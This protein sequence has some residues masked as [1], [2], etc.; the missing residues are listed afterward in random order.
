MIFGVLGRKLS[1]SLSPEIHRVFGDYEYNVFEKEP[2]EAAE[3]IK[4]G[5]YSGLNITVPYKRIA[6]E[7]ADRLSE[8]AKKTKS[9]NTLVR[10]KDGT[11]SGYNT[12]CFGFSYLLKKN[13]FSA[14]NKKVLVLGSGGAASACEFVLTEKGANVTVISRKGENNYQNLQK[15]FDADFIVNATPIGMYPN[16]PENIISL[17]GFNS[18]SGVI[19]LIYNPL[20]TG[21]L[22]QA[23][24]KNIEFANGT[25]MLAAQGLRSAELF[26]K[27]EL[28]RNLISV[29]AEKIKNRNIVI[30]GM[31]GSGKTSVGRALAEMINMNFIDTDEMIE[32]KTGR[33]AERIILESGE[34]AFRKYECEAVRDAGKMRGTVI[35]TGG[36]AVISEKNYCP[37]T[38]NGVIIWLKRDTKELAMNGRPLLKSREQAEKLYK[39]RR[40][41]YQ[42]FCDISVFSKNTVEDTAKEAAEKLKEANLL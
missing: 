42:S 24:K 13:G 29:A 34:E 5:E 7:C 17:D 41:K 35:S 36:G 9:V 38:Q 19:D 8:T 33:S 27:K 37:L 30:V 25:D 16:C 26:L 20:K 28:D 1:H 31:P 10:E 12:D 39:M 23:Q 21:I 4:N 6:Y 40:E 3:F 18:L 32:A 15:H 14:E 22:I 2:D 11:L